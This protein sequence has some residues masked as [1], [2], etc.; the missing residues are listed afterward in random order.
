MAN[1]SITPQNLWVQMLEKKHL[2]KF[3]Y[4]FTIP[5]IVG[6]YHKRGFLTDEDLQTSNCI[7]FVLET[8][9]KSASKENPVK[10][11]DC[12][13][14]E[15]ELI[16]QYLS[17]NVKDLEEIQHLKTY[18]PNVNNLIY[19]HKKES[20]ISNLDSLVSYLWNKPSTRGGVTY[21]RLISNQYFSCHKGIWAS[22]N[23][24]EIKFIENQL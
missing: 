10:I 12:P 8:I 2:L 20:D 11:F 17:T 1:S 7:R 3:D 18:H 6:A 4:G 9:L 5:F 23:V 14:L 21:A 19:W 13:E 22:F 16:L 24:D 15:N